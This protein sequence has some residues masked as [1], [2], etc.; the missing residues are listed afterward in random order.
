MVKKSKENKKSTKELPF[1]MQEF[2]ALKKQVNR[3]KSVKEK[4][5]KVQKKS[6]PKKNTTLKAKKM[7]RFDRS[8]SLKRKKNKFENVNFCFPLLYLLLDKVY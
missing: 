1:T 2:H 5:K 4:V 3:D 6:T 7:T 8:T